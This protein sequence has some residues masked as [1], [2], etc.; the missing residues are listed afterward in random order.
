MVYIII[1][2]HAGKTGTSISDDVSGTRPPRVAVVYY[3]FV[4]LHYNKENALSN[5][6]IV[7]VLCVE[8]LTNRFSV[9]GRGDITATATLLNRGV[10][11]ATRLR[12]LGHCSTT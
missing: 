10:A 5:L 11:T 2:I 9:M 8:Q 12:A 1:Y 7:S 6:P 4:I 3:C